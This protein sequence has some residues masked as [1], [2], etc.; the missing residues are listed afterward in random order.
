MSTSAPP[1]PRT[2]PADCGPAT[3]V[4]CGTIAGLAIP[5]YTGPG[6][7]IADQCGICRETFDLMYEPDQYPTVVVEGEMPELV[8]DACQDLVDADESD[9]VLAGKAA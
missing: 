6:V 5:E 4:L 2:V 9:R 7:G 1:A 8:C 3:A